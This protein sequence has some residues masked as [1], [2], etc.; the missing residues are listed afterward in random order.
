MLDIRLHELN[1]SVDRF[2]LVEGSRTFS[3]LRKPFYYKDEPTGR[4]AEFE[5]RIEWVSVTD[6]PD[7]GDT[8]QQQAWARCVVHTHIPQLKPKQLVTHT[9]LVCFPLP[10]EHYQRVAGYEWGLEAVGVSDDDLVLFGDA[11]EIPRPEAVDLL[12]WCDGYPSPIVLTARFYALSFEFEHTRHFHYPNA[13]VWRPGIGKV[14]LLRSD[15]GACLADAG[16]NTREPLL[17]FV[18]CQCCASIL[19]SPLLV[20]GVLHSVALLL[21][22]CKPSRE[23]DKAK[24]EC[25]HG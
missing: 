7:T 10:R 6:M 25:T 16:N 9:L 17:V 22:L 4:F 13:V 2:I 1:S 8:P 11:D 19:R 15:K 12:R 21:L 24:V 5:G 20:L 23:A 14:G 3:G 18:L